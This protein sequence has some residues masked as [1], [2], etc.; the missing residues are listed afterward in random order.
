MKAINIYY[1]SSSGRRFD[2]KA[3]PIRIKTANF[4]N[5]SWKRETVAL[6]YGERVVDFSK[7]AQTYQT[8][9]Y[10][11][12][13]PETL[14]ALHAAWERDIL[15]RTPGRIS[16]NGQ[17][18]ECYITGSSTYP[19]AGNAYVAN[20]IEIYCPIPLW[21]E[22]KRF[23]LYSDDGGMSSGFLDYPHGYD[24]DYAADK[25][26]TQLLWGE[27]PG[28]VS[29][30]A[31]LA[32]HCTNPTFTIDGHVFG[33]NTDIAYGGDS[34]TIDTRASAKIGEQVYRGSGESKTNLF[35]LRV[36][37]IEPFVGKANGKITWSRDF[38]IDLTVY[39]GR[40]EPSW[41]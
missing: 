14:A 3:A 13:D 34:V 28:I 27:N 4:H 30:K 21:V 19:T 2:L 11:D 32:G 6:Q 12:P 23:L 5:Y 36:G 18:I 38:A 20:E 31:I 40:S 37:E 39:I 16:W 41:L 9:L 10:L 8:T 22:T 35:H 1:I 7:K 33:V 25:S 26:G 24:Y 17:Y 15:S 29:F